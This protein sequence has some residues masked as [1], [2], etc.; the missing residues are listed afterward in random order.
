MIAEKNRENERRIDAILSRRA[1]GS[2]RL[3]S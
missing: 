3:L 2:D 1:V